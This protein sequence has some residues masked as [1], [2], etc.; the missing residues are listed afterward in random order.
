M[1]FIV[2]STKGDALRRGTSALAL[3]LA[4]LG[5]TS[6]RAQTATTTP[7]QEPAPAD[8]DGDDGSVT[9]SGDITVTGSRIASDGS[10]AASPLTVLTEQ[11]IQTQSPTNNIAD[12]V[13]QLPSIAGSTRPANSRLDLS[14]GTAGINA[15][16][17][18][19]L[20]ATRTLVLL[21]GRRSVGSTI[22]G[23]VDINTFPQQLIT[24]VEVVTGGASATYGS[25]AVAGVVNF[26]LDRKYEGLKVSADSGITSYG[27][28][29]NYSLEVAGGRSFAD[30]RGHVLV[31]GEVAHRDG[32]FQITRDWNQLGFRTISN[33]AFTNTNGQPEN[34]IRYQ[35]GT[36][37]ALPGGIVNAS[38][39]GTA[40]RLRGLYFGQGGSVNTYNYGSITS[41]SLTTGGDWFLADNSRNIGLDAQEDRRN[42]YGRLSFEIAPWIEV[43]GEASYSWQDT[44][45]NAGPQFTTTINL[46][47]DNAFLINT[48]GRD[49]L[50]GITRVT[51]GTTA[52]DLPYRKTNNQRDVQ[53]YALGAGGEFDLFGNTAV[54]NAYGQYGQTNT[55]EQLLDIQNVSRVALATDAV[56]APAGNA[57]GVAA[58][59]IVC[60]STLTTPGNGCVPLNRLGIGVTTQAMIDYILGDPYRDQKLEQTVAGINLSA[61]PFATRAGDVKIAVGAEY[62]KEKI[63]GAVPTEF[64]A[65]WQVGNYLPSFGSY[66]VKEAFLEA[67]VPLGAGVIVNGAV[68]ATDYSTSGYVTTWKIG[69]TW[70]PIEDIRFRVTRS[71]DIRAPNLAEVF[72]AGTSNTST[73]TDPFRIDPRTGN[74]GLPGVTIS[75]VFTG[76]AALDPEKANS[77]SVGVVLQPRFVPGLTISADGFRIEVNGAIDQLGAQSII[78][79]CFEGQ[80]RFC[81]AYGRDPSG[82]REL[83]FRSSPFN[84]AKLTVRGIDFETNY[85][86]PVNHVIADANGTVILRGLATRYIDNINDSGVSIPVNNV[87]NNAS[88]TPEWIFRVSATYD[89]ED[90]SITGVGRGISSGVYSNNRIEC[91]PGQCPVGRP[92]AIVNQFPTVDENN[93]SGLFY[94]DLNLTT[95]V[96]LI[97]QGKGEVFLQV[98]NVFNREP[99]LLPEG[100]LSANATYSDLLGRAFRV[101]VR[102]RTR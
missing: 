28:G 102:L 57:I 2:L 45:F 40:N 89:T 94:A 42:L 20:G 37:N 71:R 69:T 10:Q 81:A 79:R 34:L 17:L 78:N 21:D 67:A 18:R 8:D 93:V 41:S 59:T 27:D 6:V 66:D 96:D 68:R 51:I 46:Q 83:L 77:T 99:L 97:G 31:S 87:R 60:R 25:D 90:F 91:A 70:Q 50:T 98:T 15:L 38:T 39:G 22:T 72:A 53:R 92:Q 3:A 23:L 55:R 5:A 13:N 54:W 16:N 43:F 24:R 65:G 32:I 75:E 84:F 101:G 61:T 58:G 29:S 19:N 35:T 33:P 62:R 30:G 36:A 44:L 11:D 63:S 49:R 85:R 76:N 74:P 56:F 14:S 100:G 73:I 80:Q 4:I 64:R 95:K 82:D 12:F 52:V 7:I 88:G 9:S 48:L 1:R 26:I 47:A 86:L